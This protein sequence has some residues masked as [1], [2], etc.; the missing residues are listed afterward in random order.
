MHLDWHAMPFN[1]GYS[2]ESNPSYA[3]QNS[4]MNCQSTTLGAGCSLGAME[5]SVCY[6]KRG[7]GGFTCMHV[8]WDSLIEFA[9]ILGTIVHRKHAKHQAIEN[10]LCN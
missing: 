6:A 7:G 9:L 8:G 2:A 5:F 4:P 10:G 3:S 1:W